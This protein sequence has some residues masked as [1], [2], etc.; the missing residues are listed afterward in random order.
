MFVHSHEGSRGA[1]TTEEPGEFLVEL[2]HSLIDAGVDGVFTTGIHRLGPIEVYR[3]R[4]ACYGLGNFI[5]SDIQEPLGADLHEANRAL[6]RHAL[7]HGQ[8]AT[9]GDLTNVLNAGWFADPE[10]FT[11]MVALCTFGPTGLRQFDV[12]PIDLGYGRT[13]TRSGIPRLA[14]PDAVAMVIETLAEASRPFGTT[15]EVVSDPSGCGRG[16]VLSGG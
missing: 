8:P 14:D 7:G 5:C 3:N 16:R 15:I 13:L 1:G 2:A 11:S 6:M 12:I 10:W 4:P 9:D